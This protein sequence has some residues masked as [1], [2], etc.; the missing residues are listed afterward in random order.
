MF[1]HLTQSGIKE[2]EGEEVDDLLQLL[3]PFSM[4]EDTR[5]Q[6]KGQNTVYFYRNK[7]TNEK[8]AIKIFSNSID[9]QEAEKNKK[10]AKDEFK[11]MLRCLRSEHTVKPISLGIN[12]K[13]IGLLMEFGGKPLDN[14]W[15]ES[16][17]DDIYIIAYL[18]LAKGL[19][20][21]ESQNIYHGD[22]KPQNI[23]V[24]YTYINPES[25]GPKRVDEKNIKF[26][27]IDFG[28]AMHFEST[29]KFLDTILTKPK[30]RQW[31]MLYMPPEI[32]WTML[33]KV[34]PIRPKY[35][36]I[37]I[38]SLG[39]TMYSFLIKDFPERNLG[40]LK[41]EPVNYEKFMTIIEQHLDSRLKKMEREKGNALKHIIMRSLDQNPSGRCTIEEIIS[42]FTPFL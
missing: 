3:L 22:I 24:K 38:Y 35:R 5:E 37:D 17:K 20:F 2:M 28:A 16:M 34:Q 1:E 36:Q 18:Q 9:E 32:I 40:A 26:Q 12:N 6:G 13:Y 11:T 33:G 7:I 27:Y 29:E 23:L 21:F 10:Q 4:F 39:L 31:T 19:Q 41:K 42:T 15:K 8:V 30:I 14:F 25:E